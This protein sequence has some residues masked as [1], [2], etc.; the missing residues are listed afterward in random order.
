LNLLR[1]LVEKSVVR[2]G[3]NGR[4]DQ[5]E[6]LR[7]YGSKKLMQSGY[8][9]ETRR[10]HF[11]AFLRLAA[12]LDELQFGPESLAAV[13]R[14]DLEH[15]N[16]RAALSWSQD[17]QQ[18]EATLELVDH[19]W[20]FW[21]RRG[22]YQEGGQWTI[23]AIQQA[24]E[25]ESVHMCIAMTSAAVFSFIQGQ[26]GQGES[27]ACRAMELARRLEDP[28]ALI[29]AYGTYTFTSVNTEQALEGL[30]TGISLIQKTGKL[31]PL[32]PLYYQ[33]A[34]T[35]LH[36]S[37]RYTEAEDYYLKSIALFRQMGAADFVADP[38]GRLGEVAL[39][40]GRLQEAY[41]LTVESIT[42]A[43]ATGYDLAFGA[44]GSSRLGLI[45]L[46]LGEVEA[47]QRSVETALLL[48]DDHRDVRVKQE[49][50]AVLS[51]VALARGDVETAANLLRS[52]LNICDKFY[53]Q[54][55]ATQKLEGTPDALPVDLIGLCSRASLVAAAQGNDE[56]AVS[57]YNLAESLNSQSGQRMIPALQAKLVESIAS[58]RSHLPE[59]VFNT[60]WEKGQRLSLSEAFEFL[61]K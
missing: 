49:A 6:L 13:A 38:L 2:A 25:L 11:E 1:R 18:P 29:A 36:S 47:A 19:L 57:L 24:G 26:Y 41:D 51:E 50:L 44:W 46:Y 30:H 31:R 45:Q 34:A 21:S 17:S 12:R 28:E 60:L 33:G 52:S 40:A 23:Q 10:R 15:D 4:Y 22:Y 55:L 27:L 58:L 48:C 39:Q 8:E 14:F 56:R 9:T 3:E 16:L 59:N 61:L 43:R 42:A 37:G 53:H 35:W 20:F 54:L 5:H 7:Q 32:L